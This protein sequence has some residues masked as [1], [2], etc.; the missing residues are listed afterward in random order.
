M[1]GCMSPISPSS[2]ALGVSAATEFDHQHVDGAG[3]HQRVGDL[4][5]LLAVVGLGDQQVLDLDAELPGVDGIERMLGV[6]EGADTALLLR[7]G[8]DLEGQ[9]G[10]AGRLRPVNLDDAAARQPADAERDVEPERARGHGLHLDRRSLAPSRMIEPLPCIFSIWA[11]AA[12][13][14][15]CLSMLPPSTTRSCGFSM[16]G[17]L[18][19]ELQTEAKTR[20]WLST[21]YTVCSRCATGSV[22]PAAS[23]PLKPSGPYPSRDGGGIGRRW[24]SE[25]RSCT[26]GR[27]TRSLRAGARAARR[28]DRNW[29][30]ARASSAWP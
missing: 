17:P 23:Q 9:S 21:V 14:A 12:S 7:L 5:R 24:E 10:L 3:A 13:R 11:S 16:G 19:H 25:P 29:R 20:L 18:F 28:W 30:G 1:P 27:L 22:A 8:Q 26:D 2:S 15:F 6:D 4:Q